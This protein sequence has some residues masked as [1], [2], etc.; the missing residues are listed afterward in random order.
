[1]KHRPD[2][3]SRPAKPAPNIYRRYKTEEPAKQKAKDKIDEFT[4]FILGAFK[5]PRFIFGLLVGYLLNQLILRPLL[6]S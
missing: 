1:M 6:F 3:I 5:S 4:A 2:K